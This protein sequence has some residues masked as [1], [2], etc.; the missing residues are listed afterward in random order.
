MSMR[1]YVTM[2]NSLTANNAPLEMK[3]LGLVIFIWILFW[4]GMA[5]WR[6]AKNDQR[7]WYIAIL[8]LNTL[9]ILEII[10][11]FKFA[12]KPMTLRELMFWK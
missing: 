12:K 5:L 7:N 8:L 10:F 11:L 2:F 3:L 1:Y 4:K 9:G 6:A